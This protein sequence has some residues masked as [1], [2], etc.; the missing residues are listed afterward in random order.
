MLFNQIK[1]NKEEIMKLTKAKT[2]EFFNLIKDEN[3][4]T[5]NETMSI[6]TQHPELSNTVV[7]GMAKGIDGYS[8]LMLAVNFYK[9]RSAL[10]LIKKGADVNFRDESPFRHIY[11]PVFIDLLNMLIHCDKVEDTKTFEEGLEVWALMAANG[12]DYSKKTLSVDGVNKSENCVQ[13]CIRMMSAR[14][15]NK[16]KI[17]HETKYAP[18]NPY[19]SRYILGEQSRDARKEKLYELIMEKLVGCISEDLYQ[20][21]DANKHR[22]SGH[23]F[24]IEPN[25]IK[26][27]DS[28]PLEIANKYLSEKFGY[29]MKNITDDSLINTFTSNSNF[30]PRQIYKSS[31]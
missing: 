6:L 24:E 21:I 8:S 12:L 16:H 20:E 3:I 18:P 5:Y 26:I 7:C 11:R 29:P 23:I 9:L 30:L 22:H 2:K 25:Q 28:F 17:Y 13:A 15:E 4:D 1:R 14:Y 19:I 10:E 27:I 31:R